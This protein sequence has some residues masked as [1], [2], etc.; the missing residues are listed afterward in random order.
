M[1]EVI[2]EKWSDLRYVLMVLL[3]GFSGREAKNDL[4]SGLSNWTNA[5]VI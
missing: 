5:I 2:M 4:V 3:T 1:Q